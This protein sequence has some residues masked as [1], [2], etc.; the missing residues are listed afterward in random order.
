MTKQLPDE[1]LYDARLVERHIRQGLITRQDVEK[2][3]GAAED[4]TE[5]A[6]WLSLAEMQRP[7][8]SRRTDTGSKDS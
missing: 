2:H 4:L 5:Q 3:R 6:D 7:D 1:V 8:G